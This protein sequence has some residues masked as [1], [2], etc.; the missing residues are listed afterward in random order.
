ML[1]VKTLIPHHNAYGAAYAKGQ[2][3]EYPVPAA[4]AAVLI[5]QGLVEVVG[6][7]PA[8]DT[9]GEIDAGE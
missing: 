6:E 4:E 1:T 2:G 5:D 3:D 9:A 8:N 7:D